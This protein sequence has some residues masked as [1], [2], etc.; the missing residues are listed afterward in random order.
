MPGVVVVSKRG[1]GRQLASNNQQDN[2]HCHKYNYQ[3]DKNQEDNNQQDND[4]CHKNQ[5]T[6]QQDNNQQDTNQQDKNQQDNDHC[7]KQS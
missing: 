7:H 2:D 3:Q 5:D 1:S 6:N 4:H